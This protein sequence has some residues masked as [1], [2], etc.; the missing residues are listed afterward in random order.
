M[1]EL[2]QRTTAKKPSPSPSP[3]ALAKADDKSS[4]SL[5][6]LART[7]VLLLLLSSATSYFVTRKSFVWNLAR[8]SWTQPGAIQAWL[9]SPQLSLQTSNHP[10]SKPSFKDHE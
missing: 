6:D 3:A 2:R 1:A 9:V 5:L 7:L 10:T 4:F 8:P